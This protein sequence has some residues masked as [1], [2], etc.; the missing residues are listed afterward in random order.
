M[1]SIHEIDKMQLDREWVNQ[2]AL[3]VEYAEKLADAS[4]TLDYAKS[5]LDVVTATLDKDIRLFPQN[6]GIEK[7]TETVITN[8]ILLQKNHQTAAKDVVIAKHDVAILRAAV[9]GLDQRKAALENLV[10]L[11]LSSYYAQPQA[12]TDARD[13]M[14]ADGKKRFADRTKPNRKG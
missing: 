2:P 14:E 10:K 11:L 12:P 9:D 6:Y 1:K 5:T 13:K 8:T 7:L 3:Y 4:Q